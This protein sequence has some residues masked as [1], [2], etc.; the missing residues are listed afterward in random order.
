MA[1]ALALASLL[2]FSSSFFY[3]EMRSAKENRAGRIFRFSDWRHQA[4]VAIPVAT[5]AF[6]TLI[7]A[8][9]ACLWPTLS[10]LSPIVTILIVKGIFAAISLAERIRRS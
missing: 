10:L 1:Y 3:L 5:A 9:M 7:I 2:A 4:P 6:C 8:T